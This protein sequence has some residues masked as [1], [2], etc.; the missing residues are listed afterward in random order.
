[1]EMGFCEIPHI[2][3]QISSKEKG[4]HGFKPQ[5][6]HDVPDHNF[7]QSLQHPER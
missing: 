4:Y 5:E 6:E 3:H 1:M 2:C 7:S